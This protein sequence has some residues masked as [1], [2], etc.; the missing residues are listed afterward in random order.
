MNYFKDILM[1][2]FL[3]I[4]P[5]KM[6]FH[7]LKLSSNCL[8]YFSFDLTIRDFYLLPYTHPFHHQIFH[9][10]SFSFFLNPNFYLNS[11]NYFSI[12]N[13]TGI[14]FLVF[15]ISFRISALLLLTSSLN[16]SLYF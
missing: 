10:S 15:S 9:H 6:D 4:C 14:N 7:H 5:L 16:D 3:T 12:F 1:K 2:Q 8:K 11:H 13:F